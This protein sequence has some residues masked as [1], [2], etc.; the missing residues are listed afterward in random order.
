MK[1]TDPSPLFTA[2]IAGACWLMTFITSGFAMW[3]GSKL[4]VFGNA[5]ATATK[6]LAHEML[7]QSATAAMLV[8]GAFYLVVTL[9]VYELLKPVNRTLSLL[10]AFFSLV[11]CA[12][13]A[14]GGL[15]DLAPLVLLRG[16]GYLSVFTLEQLQALALALLKVRLEAN[17]IGLVFFGFHCLL[18]GYLILRSTFLPR[19]IGGLMMFAGLGWLTCL[20]PP[21]AESLAPYNVIP[22]SL[23]EIS[24]TLWLVVKGVNV[25]RWNEQASQRVAVATAAPA[26]A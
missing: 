22:G 11:G 9:L 20:L 21:L 24:L 12:V 8:S 23:G 2:R 18:I 16:A 26:L 1:H 15:F 5:T 7:F 13:G 6:I 17:N 19:M 3:V 4:I 10:A 25:K 14:L